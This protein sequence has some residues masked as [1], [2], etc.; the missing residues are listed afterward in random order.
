MERGLLLSLL[1]ARLTREWRKNEKRITAIIQA[2]TTGYF[3]M[4]DTLVLNNVSTT[5]IALTAFAHLS[6]GSHP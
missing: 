3:Q 4:A 1:A 5:P 6:K 2:E